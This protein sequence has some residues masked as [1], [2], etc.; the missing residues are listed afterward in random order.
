[1]AIPN[2]YLTLISITP[3][4]C[5]TLN[6]KSKFVLLSFLIKELHIEM[7]LN[8]SMC[9]L[10]KY[11]IRGHTFNI[12]QKRI[13][14]FLFILIKRIFLVVQANFVKVALKL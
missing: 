12:C 14:Y 1:M 5:F 7:N 3:L 8:C 10:K 6:Q 4:G 9:L 13:L 2:N 11:I